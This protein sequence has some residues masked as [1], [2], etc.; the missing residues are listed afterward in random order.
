MLGIPLGLAYANAGEWLIHKYI[1]HGVGKKRNSFWSFHWREHHRNCRRNDFRDADYERGF[2]GN[3]SQ[4]KEAAA[5]LALVA[6]HAPL[7]SVAPYFAGT[8][9]YSGLNYLQKHRKSHLNVEWGKQH[10]RHHYDHHM[11]KNQ[12][13]NWGV[14]HAWMDWLMGTRVE[15]EYDE[16]RHPKPQ[17]E[18][19]IPLQDVVLPGATENV[20]EVATDSEE[21]AA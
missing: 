18:E 5:V 13:A 4:G 8:V 12:D 2:L 9:I 16:P 14:T 21:D 7:F 19:E 17:R 6:L 11:G 1:L 10:L 3:H 15:Y 20:V